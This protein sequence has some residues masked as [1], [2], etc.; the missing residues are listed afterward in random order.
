[1]DILTN[2]WS[3]LFENENKDEMYRCHKCIPTNKENNGKKRENLTKQRKKKFKNKE[4]SHQ[5]C[6]AYLF[7]TIIMK[8]KTI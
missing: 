3:L 8:K 6:I 2:N 4:I 7:E 1:M 5:K